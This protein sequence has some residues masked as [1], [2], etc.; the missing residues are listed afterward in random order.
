MINFT[1]ENYLQQD[2]AMR[3]DEALEIYNGI[4]GQADKEDEDFRTLWEDLIDEASKYVIVRS[5]WAL[6]T[7]DERISVNAS[8][9]AQHRMVSRYS[10]GGGVLSDP[11]E[12]TL[13]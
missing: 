10:N 2:S 5:K 4:M 8:R 6:Q 12:V 9:S 1:F 7:Q 13:P 11:I 3:I